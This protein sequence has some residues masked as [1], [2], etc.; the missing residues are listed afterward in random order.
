M[1]EDWR[2]TMCDAAVTDGL[3]VISAVRQSLKLER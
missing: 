3:R 2:P 1:I